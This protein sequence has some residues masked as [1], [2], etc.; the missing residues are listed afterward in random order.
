[1]ASPFVLEL[2]GPAGSGKTTISDALRGFGISL[3]SDRASVRASSNLP[4]FV[5]SGLRLLP[6]LLRRPRDGRWYTRDELA[7]MF[8]L[9]GTR[10]VLRDLGRGSCAVALDH[11]P[12]FQMAHLREFGPERLRGPSFERWWSSLFRQWGETLNLV[13]WLD[14]PDEVLIERIRNREQRH[15]IK[16]ISG[17]EAHI[18]LGRY[19][20]AYA[21]VLARLTSGSALQVLRFSTDSH[22]T[23]HVTR[24]ILEEIAAATGRGRSHVAYSD[25][26]DPAAPSP[27]T[28]VRDANS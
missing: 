3:L 16:E 5:T 13:V 28:A 25:S 2:A 22:S 23:D 11:G 24:R 10:R 17:Q 15:D 21:S 9:T 26:S 18:L 19:R 4:F 6:T 14:A 1:M 7:R 12:A 8:Y 20:S 27:V